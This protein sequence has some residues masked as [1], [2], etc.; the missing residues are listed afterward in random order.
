MKKI[1]LIL[2]TAALTF[3]SCERI[4]FGDINQDPKVTREG[5][6]D[7]LLRGAMTSFA[8][9]GGRVYYSNAT[10]YAQYQSQTTYTQEQRY[11]QYKGSWYSYY[12]N[13]LASLKEVN[14]ILD[15][16]RGDTKNFRAIAELTSIM[17]WKRIT[18]TFGDVPY[19]DALQGLD[20]LTPSF[21]SQR[22]IYIDLISR[23]TAA[24][25]LLD[26]SAFTPDAN[27]DI[28][29][30]G[31]VNKWGKFA[32]SLILSLSLQISKTSDATSV[33]QVAFQEALA[34]TYGVIENNA[35]NMVFRPD[36]FGGISNP[37]SKSRSGDFNVSKEMTDALKGDFPMGWGPAMTDYKNSTSNHTPDNRINAFSEGGGDGLPF[38]Y[39]SY[40]DSATGMNDNLDGA[41]SPFVYMSAAYTWL[42]RA[43]G[44]LIYATGENTDTLLTN[45]IVASFEQFGVNGG[46]AQAVARIADAAANSYAQIIGEEKWFALFPD[47]YAAWSEQR[48]TGWPQLHPAPESVNGG[49]VPLRMLY[50]DNTR[51][52]NTQ[53][54][55]QGVNGLVPTEDVNTSKMWW[56]Q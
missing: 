52:V 16:P 18:D 5:N 9:G 22:D 25:D 8:S 49:V 24:R 19:T 39:A 50:P 31:N 53:G 30:G 21:T 47:G 28:F 35:D 2:I 20:N 45:G 4:D 11:V 32:N 36:A 23:A 51:N 37:I 26:G 42:N 44:S 55:Q 33:G 48:R 38:G 17:I 41:D 56:A 6:L 10:L 40:P 7:G 3:S 13:Q 34:N 46:A 15:D 12:V 54:W 43:E 14:G 29:Y 27:T 1:F